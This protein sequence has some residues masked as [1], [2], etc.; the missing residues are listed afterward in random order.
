[1]VSITPRSPATNVNEWFAV[2]ARSASGEEWGRELFPGRWRRST[3]VAPPGD[4]CLPNLA[5]PRTAR[6]RSLLAITWGTSART[7]DGSSA[8]YH[9]GCGQRP[10]RVGELNWRMWCRGPERTRHSGTGAT[11][12]SPSTRRPVRAGSAAA[13]RD[14]SGGPPQV[15]WRSPVNTCRRRR[16]GSLIVRT[17]GRHR[18][19]ARR[20]S[21]AEQL[22]VAIRKGLSD[23]QAD[24]RQP[25]RA[26]GCSR[27]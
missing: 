17:V 15:P 11:A 10:G 18:Q 13:R 26:L 4:G 7:T 9:G 25:D 14:G 24:A 12:A 27:N 8:S 22:P 6:A 19:Q 20:V 5:G 16:S 23:R 1:M 2:R 3:C 21:T